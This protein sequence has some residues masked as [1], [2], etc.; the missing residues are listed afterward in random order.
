[1]RSKVPFKEN[2]LAFWLLLDAFFMPNEYRY[3][4]LSEVAE[5]P[6]DDPDPEYPPDLEEINPFDDRVSACREKASYGRKGKGR[7]P[8]D[9]PLLI[10]IDSMTEHHPLYFYIC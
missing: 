9:R 10:W 7:S 5:S 3:L 2:F 4:S 8:M 1:M 6:V